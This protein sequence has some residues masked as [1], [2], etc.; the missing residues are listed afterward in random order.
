[1]SLKNSIYLNQKAQALSDQYGYD[2]LVGGLH[3]FD[4]V[5]RDTFILLLENGLLP[6]SK[7]LDIGCGV[8]R[9]GYW[10]IRF[11]DPDCYYGTEVREK[12]VEIGK[13]H[14]LTPE[15]ILS[16][17]P[18]IKLVKDKGSMI[19]PDFNTRFD[20]FLARS[21]W[22]HTP[23]KEILNTLDSFIRLRTKDGVLL[24]SFYP[25]NND[26][27]DYRGDDWHGQP[28]RHYFYWIAKECKKREL[29][30]EEVIDQ[31]PTGK[32]VKRLARQHW[33]RISK[34]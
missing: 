26:E 18:V 6:H 3:L 12:T 2:S 10:L 28:I 7:V 23:K 20:Y 19:L 22:T 30:A 33:I 13:D 9:S 29:Q 15:L 16:K 11:L 1:M 25:A 27:E 32:E 17:R 24:T 5:G 21:I 4:M 31:G 14:F 8:F 34:S